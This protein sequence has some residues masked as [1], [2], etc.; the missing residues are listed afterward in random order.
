MDLPTEIKKAEN[1]LIQF[2]KAI[3][4]LTEDDAD[5]YYIAFFNIWKYL[6][7][8][9]DSEHSLYAKRLLINYARVL[10]EKAHLLPVLPESCWFNFRLS[11]HLIRN[12]LKTV[13]KERPDLISGYERIRNQYPDEIFFQDLDNFRAGIEK[14]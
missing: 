8:N 1:L 9:P 14:D 2:E 4:N 7:T 6:I 12:D 5:N 10:L 13:F 3:P 11:L